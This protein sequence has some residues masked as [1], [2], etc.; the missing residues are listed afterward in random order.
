[1]AIAAKKT[2]TLS[3]WLDTGAVKSGFVT[4]LKNSKKAMKRVGKDQKKKRKKKEE[5]RKKGGKT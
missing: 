3:Y 1:M 4:S 5:K 2:H